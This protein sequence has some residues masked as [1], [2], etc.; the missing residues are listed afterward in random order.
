MH[1]GKYTALEMLQ[2]NMQGSRESNDKIRE[3][4]WIKQPP[5]EKSIGLATQ[6]EFHTADQSICY[7]YSLYR[8]VSTLL[9]LT[10]TITFT[11]EMLKFSKEQG[12]FIMWEIIEN[13]LEDFEEILF[14][15]TWNLSF[16]IVLQTC[17][18]LVL[19]LYILS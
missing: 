13:L 19:E 12:I 15:S 11:V 7:W 6:A 1:W 16:L 10:T 2:I 8:V 5:Q 18:E 17:V 4:P 9:A 14:S 3:E